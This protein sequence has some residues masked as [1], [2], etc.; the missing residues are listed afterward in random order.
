M[1]AQQI[2]VQ[3]E[4]G[5]FTYTWY[6]DNR[7]MVTDY[8]AGK[9]YDGYEL[10]YKNFVCEILYLFTDYDGEKYLALLMKDILQMGNPFTMNM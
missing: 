10:A 1:I 8:Q 7:E 5:S 3:N 6:T 4:R 9:L 2:N